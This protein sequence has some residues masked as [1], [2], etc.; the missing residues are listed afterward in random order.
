MSGKEIREV[1]IGAAEALLTRFGRRQAWQASGLLPPT[2]L[3]WCLFSAEFR[4]LPFL[5][6]Q[7]MED[8]ESEEMHEAL[9]L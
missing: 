7:L 4:N 5:H 8:Y 6:E 2:S 3:N 9:I 1:E